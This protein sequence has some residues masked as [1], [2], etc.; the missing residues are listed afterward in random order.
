MIRKPGFI[1]CLVIAFSLGQGNDKALEE[2]NCKFIADGQYFSIYAD[3][4]ADA[5]SITSKLKFDYL[6]FS[7]E[8]LKGA[9]DDQKQLLVKTIDA[10]F[11]EVSDIID[12]HIYSFKG[13][14]RVVPDKLALES[15]IKQVYGQDFGERSL[16]YFEKNT[17]YISQADLNLGVLGHEIAHAIISNF[18]VVPPPPKVQ[19]ILAGYVEYSLKKKHGF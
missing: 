17:I 7:D 14:I 2:D 16:Y 5:Y 15:L 6:V 12:I 18:F 3:P 8:L 1:I 11:L 4:S 19:E 9:D 13:V 10:L